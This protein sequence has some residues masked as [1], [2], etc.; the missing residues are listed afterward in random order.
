MGSTGEPERKRRHL[1]N[2]SPTLKKQP[3]APSSD[4]KKVDAAVLQYQNQKLAQQLEA[5][6]SD[7]HA[8]ENKFNQLKSK[9]AEYDDTLILVN[10]AWKQLVDDL[11]L[12]AIRAG[13]CTNGVRVL[14]LSQPLEDGSGASCPPEETFLCRLLETGATE[15]SIKNVSANYVENALGT[16]HASTMKTM[17]YLVQA[18][19]AQ[20]AKNEELSS[21]LRGRLTEDEASKKLQK[22]DDNLRDE[23]RNLQAAMDALHLKHKQYASDMQT[24]QDG[25][26]K[27]QS[28]I[29]RLKGELEETLAELEE[30][31]CKLASLKS[32]RDA[33]LGASFPGLHLGNKIDFG[34]KAGDKSREL[35]EMEAAMEEFKTLAASRLSELQETHQ[36][37]LKIAQRLE[38]MQDSLNDEKHVLSCRPYVLLNDR[39]QHLKVEVDRYQSL[40]E[41]LQAERDNFLRREKEMSLKVETSD[42]ARRTTAVADAR[43][44]ELE[45]NLQECMAD[46][47]L[48][49]IR[50]EEALQESG[51][52]DII[53]EF[54]VMV[55]TLHKEM[56]M[57]QA[58]LNKFKETACE[59]HSLRAE[60]HSL[61]IILNRKSG[62]CKNLS[63][64]C[65]DQAAEIK[66][67]QALVMELRET[68]Q[69]LKL[70]L[71][72]Y[73]RESTDSRDV[74]EARQAECKA[75]A[76]VHK[77]KSA[78]DEHSLELRVKAANEAEAVC[79]QRLALAEAE[80]AELR[81]KLDASERDVLELTEALK[82]KNEEGEA[83]IAEIETIGQAYEDMQTQNQR[84]LQQITERDDYN[85]KLVSESV[86]AKQVQNSLLMEK[87]AM[88]KQ[89]QLANASTEVYKQKIIRL[90]E[91][92]RILLEQIGKVTEDG[93]Q[94]VFNLESTKRNL[95]EVEKESKSLKS[96]LEEVRN[97]FEQCR[98]KVTEL[99][100]ELMNERFEKKRIEEELVSLNSKVSRLNDGGTVAEKL[101]EEIKAYKQIL[102]CSV[103][104]DRSK[105]V[106]ITK[107]FHLFC[108]P[109]IQRNLEIRHRKCPACGTGF[110]QNDVRNVYI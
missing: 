42:V 101:Q 107:C 36:E 2:I 104:H 39:L 87:Q 60:V 47:N 49:E 53:T 80:I 24:F 98:H 65:A 27:D 102:K 8:L 76:Q 54:K 66:S 61:T 90:E 16:R 78:L 21:I 10:R 88:T 82:A 11:E 44:A 32:Q 29:K 26:A 55:S 40:V 93:R 31:K 79:Q 37:K 14:D 74:M 23:I 105:E 89:L 100:V 18:I 95:V 35:R 50:L 57:M 69:E 70:I 1:N 7:F 103:C 56:G 22:D 77:L 25:H 6:K 3:P 13:G 108:A 38:H 46:R 59:V 72:M 92:I 109:C 83:Y 52:K 85:I 96:S 84:L 34:E 86:K 73:G 28:E 97:E 63:D 58:H 5:Q 71:E 4:E 94:H 20:R 67:L 91:Q 75:W 15:S 64:K 19:D 62:E 30:S 81:Q 99:Q 68:E 9:Q 33:A 51:R 45:S 110:G 12:L 48:F 106:V 41:S 43:I 17:Q